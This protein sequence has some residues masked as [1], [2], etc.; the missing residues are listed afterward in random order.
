[1]GGFPP[2]RAL[3]RPTDLVLNERIVGWIPTVGGRP[4]SVLA[5]GENRI[6][7]VRAKPPRR[8]THLYLRSRRADLNADPDRVAPARRVSFTDATYVRPRGRSS[9]RKPRAVR[10]SELSEPLSYYILFDFTY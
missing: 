3:L 5:P 6:A 10:K 9:S 1:M 4:Y 2:A 7:G 8:T